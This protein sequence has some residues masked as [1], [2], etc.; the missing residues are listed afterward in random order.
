MSD[1]SRLVFK[2]IAVECDVYMGCAYDMRTS[3]LSDK[4][5]DVFR[6]TGRVTSNAIIIYFPRKLQHDMLISRHREKVESLSVN[7]IYLV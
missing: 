7:D 2:V 4:L 3:S 5:I 6:V 1:I